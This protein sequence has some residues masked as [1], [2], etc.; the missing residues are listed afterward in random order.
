MSSSPRRSTSRS[1]ARKR[2]LHR[3][4]ATGKVVVTGGAG[5]VGRRLAEMLHD[6]GNDV[7]SF[8]KV[9]A[10]PGHQ[11]ICH[12]IGDLTCLADVLAVC[13]G[14]VCVYHIAAAVGPYLPQ[15]VYKAVNQVGTHNVITACQRLGVSKIVMASS[16]STR[17][18]WGVDIDGLSEA[19]LPALPLPEYMQAY[20]ETKAA[21]EL[22]LRA[23]CSESLMTV[24]VAPHQVY[25]PRDSL[26][27]PA[28]LDAGLSGRLRRFGSKRNRVAFT[29]V[30]NYCHALMLAEKA[31]FPK[32]RALGGFYIVTDGATHPRPEGFADFWDVL[33]AACVAMGAP[34]FARKWPYPHTVL[35]AA[36]AAA[37]ALGSLT[38][39]TY[40]VK[41]SALMLERCGPAMD[42]TLGAPLT[43]LLC[44]AVRSST[45][46]R[47]SLRQCTAG[48]TL[49]QR[50]VTCT[51]SR[52]FLLTRG[53][54][55]R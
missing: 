5:F 40:K 38:G 7:V 43:G 49:P 34:S 47:C 1:P 2:V 54:A 18:Q 48:S 55:G 3:S 17:F 11:E 33:D 9:A 27:L 8:D 30:D 16:P 21:G 4:Q 45:P 39:T 51:T 32:S 6:R 19:T 37:T 20:A 46:L 28:V 29:F 52:S 44:N 15:P 53:G 12:V 42:P 26:F 22:A 41:R 50:V 23:A 14:A 31:L 36:A 10:P 13:E 25:G 24:A 35:A